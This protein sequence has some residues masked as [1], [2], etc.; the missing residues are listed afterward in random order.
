MATLTCSESKELQYG[1]CLPARIQH[2]EV[3]PSFLYI[4][5]NR[6]TNEPTRPTFDIPVSPL[7]IKT[8]SPSSLPPPLSISS[9]IKTFYTA[10]EVSSIKMDLTQSPIDMQVASSAAKE[11]G[12]AQEPGKAP[13]KNASASTESSV[14]G[15][16]TLSNTEPKKEYNPQRS[17]GPAKKHRSKSMDQASRSSSMNSSNRP[18][19]RHNRTSSYRQSQSSRVA[20]PEKESSSRKGE[21]DLLTLHR[22][23]CRLFESFNSPEQESQSSHGPLAPSEN[24]PIR[25][26]TAPTASAATT[27]PMKGGPVQL[28]PMPLPLHSKQ[29]PAAPEQAENLPGGSHQQEYPPLGGDSEEGEAET[30]DNAPVH[31]SIPPTV[32]DWTSPATRRREYEKIDRSSHGIRGA[33]R[34]YA[35]KWCQSKS[36]R[37]LF[38]EECKGGKKMY[39]GSVRRFRMDIPDDESEADE[40]IEKDDKFK[41]A[42]LKSSVTEVNPDDGHDVIPKDQTRRFRLNLKRN[43][44]SDTTA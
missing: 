5:P 11:D 6:E 22:D 38:F 17:P 14:P 35:P 34:R 9:D 28:P 31:P 32:I 2:P 21:R 29:L 15:R 27:T 4:P 23:S 12:D 1:S 19:R 44:K 8:P 13:Q 42:E 16:K 41:K 40:N 25:S 18:S 30:G 3:A 36:Q 26:Y 39:E 33:W 20:Y 7:L 37:T 10:F 43:R 24:C